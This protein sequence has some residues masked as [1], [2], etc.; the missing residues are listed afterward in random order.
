MGQTP[1]TSGG[2]SG[3][4]PHAAAATATIAQ[5]SLPGCSHSEILV[6]DEP[7]GSILASF[8]SARFPRGRPEETPKLGQNFCPNS[9]AL[10]GPVLG[11]L[12]AIGGGLSNSDKDV[13]EEADGVTCLGGGFDG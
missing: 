9:G 8:W 1:G 13:F 4:D 2:A 7:E 12:G 3:A 11:V 5:G 6:C 10:S